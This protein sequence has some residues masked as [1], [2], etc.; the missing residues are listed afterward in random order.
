MGR[1]G[2]VALAGAGDGDSLWTGL[3]G[4]GTGESPRCRADV[5]PGTAVPTG[6]RDGAWAHPPRGCLGRSCRSPGRTCHLPGPGPEAEKGQR[7]GRGGRGC[8]GGA[9]LE[10]GRTRSCLAA[11]HLWDRQLSEQPPDEGRVL[12]WAGGG[13]S[14]QEGSPL[15]KPL[16]PIPTP[17]HTHTHPYTYLHPH[18]GLHPYSMGPKGAQ[19]TGLRGCSQLGLDQGSRLGHPQPDS[20]TRAFWVLGLG[21]SRPVCVCGRGAGVGC[22]RA[23]VGRPPPLP[24]PR[25]PGWSPLSSPTGSAWW[26][27]PLSSPPGWGHRG[28]DQGLRRPAG[29]SHPQPFPRPAPPLLSVPPDPQ[30]SAQPSPAPPSTPGKPP[31]RRGAP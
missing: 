12:G 28:G 7:W 30:A 2:Q 1:T 13:R 6:G 3:P 10:G 14:A 21:D 31:S 18:P 26:L 11:S 23:G 8:R 29:G 17:T 27:P 16:T 19:L 20:R 22:L 15:P 4:Q 9:W 24:S 25:H 5:G